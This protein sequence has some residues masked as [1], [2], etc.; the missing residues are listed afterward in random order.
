M[1]ARTMSCRGI[2]VGVGDGVGGGGAIGAAALSVLQPA[3]KKAA[4]EASP[5]A[6]TVRRDTRARST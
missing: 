4:A 1:V 5:P 2:G 6:I 3:A